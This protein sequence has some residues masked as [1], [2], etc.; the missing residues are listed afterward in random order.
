ME[1]RVAFSRPVFVSIPRIM[2]LTHY[3]ADTFRSIA[4]NTTDGSLGHGGEIWKS[5]P[6]MTDSKK[7]S[8][9]SP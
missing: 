5:R 3:S 9:A 7:H 4:R 8:S 6:L 1:T 2:S